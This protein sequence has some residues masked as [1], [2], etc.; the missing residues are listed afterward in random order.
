M[1]ELMS[2]RDRERKIKRGRKLESSTRVYFM[3]FSDDADVLFLFRRD[4]GHCR[5]L[6]PCNSDSDLFFSS[7]YCFFSSCRRVLLTARSR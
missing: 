7:S 3:D 6:A 1:S 4:T 5:L 2:E